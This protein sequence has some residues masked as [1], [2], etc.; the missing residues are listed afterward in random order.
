MIGHFVYLFIVVKAVPLL[1]I[2]LNIAEIV[3][4]IHFSLV[5]YDP[6]KLKFLHFQLLSILIVVAG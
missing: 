4:R 1:T 5:I 6:E 3:T 2:L